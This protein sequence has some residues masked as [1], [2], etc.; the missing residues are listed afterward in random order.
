MTLSFLGKD[1][2]G[3][4]LTAAA[5]GVFLFCLLFFLLLIKGK[6][7][8]SCLLSTACSGNGTHSAHLG[9]EAHSRMGKGPL[10]AY[11]EC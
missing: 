5:S 9:A 3:L 1:W 7:S 10:L 6:D 11:P 8:Q 4:Y 2:C